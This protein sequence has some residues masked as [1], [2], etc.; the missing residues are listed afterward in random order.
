MFICVY[1]K[2]NQICSLHLA[3]SV[4][5][6]EMK[7]FLMTNIVIRSAAPSDFDRL[8]IVEVAAA[9][10]FKAA[11]LPEIAHM[12]PAPPEYYHQLP[13]SAFVLVAETRKQVIG[14]CLVTELCGQAHLKE[15]SVASEFAGK[16]VGKQLLQ[17]ALTAA[18][19]RDFTMMTLTTFKDVPFNAPF[20]KSLGF[21]EFQPDTSW[22]HLKT[23]LENEKKSMLGHY[24]RVAM[25]KTIK[26]QPE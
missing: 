24:G 15:I 4:Q 11:G 13:T 8:P 6:W 21:V 9:Q 3:Q 26:T 19:I 12:P 17:Q 16:G 5:N 23:L 10:A 22:A 25:M 2:V 1:I 7:F 18:Q 14:F 20:Y